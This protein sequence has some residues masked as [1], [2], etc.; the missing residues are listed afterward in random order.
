MLVVGPADGDLQALCATWGV[1][2][3]PHDAPDG[4]DQ[5]D[6]W[7]QAPS[8]AP[9]KSFR[10]SCERH[11]LA[12]ELAEL[13]NTTTLLM[14]VFV[15]CCLLLAGVLC[16]F[17]ASAQ[18]SLVQGAVQEPGGCIR[19]TNTSQNQR[20]GAWHDCQLNLEADFDL[21]FTVNFGT[22]DA[23]GADG[24]VFVLQPFGV[25]NNVIGS[26][27][28]PSGMR[29][30]HSTLRWRWRWTRGKMPTWATRGSTTSR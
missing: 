2:F 18:W 15:S 16:P 5:V 26:T 17:G 20:G 24:I 11:A 30:A 23:D 25:G 7:L 9:H 29:M 22:T 6:S 13:F 8:P 4:R 27:G 12:S 14:R 3:V 1:T 21:E 28:G 19:L 10:A